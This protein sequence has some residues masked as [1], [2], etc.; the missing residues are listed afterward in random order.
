MPE[1]KL[2]R[3]P[4]LD[5]AVADLLSGLEQKQAETKL[6]RRE[7]EKK[8]RERAKIQ[9]RREQRVTY[10]LPP[11]IRQNVKDLAEKEGVPASQLVA[12]ALLRFLRDLAQQQVDLG[13]YKQPSRSPRYDCNLILPDSL[14]PASTR[15]SRKE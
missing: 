5:P 3:R 15:R 12:L 6:P 14:F 2:E 13:Q 1:R 7:R 10:D 4:I 11:H 9:A 8:V